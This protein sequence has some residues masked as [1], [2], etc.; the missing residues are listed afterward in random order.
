MTRKGREQSRGLWSLSA[1]AAPYLSHTCARPHLGHPHI[2]SSFSASNTPVAAV[3]VGHAVT[4][5]CA[6]LA[7]PQP[8]TAPQHRS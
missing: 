2:S 4:S 5:R 7:R 3:D 8:A 1:R 6:T